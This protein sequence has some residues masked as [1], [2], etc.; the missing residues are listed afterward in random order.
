MVSFLLQWHAIPLLIRS[1]H[2]RA[3]FMYMVP[4]F[5]AYY[6]SL[7]VDPGW[8]IFLLRE[9]YTQCR[10][11]RQTLQDEDTK[12]WRHTLSE[13]DTNGFTDPALWATGQSKRS[14]NPRIR[15]NANFLFALE[16]QVT[17][18]RQRACCASAKPSGIR[19]TLA[20]SYPR[21]A[22]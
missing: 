1:T 7:A 9:A 20:S 8:A 12:L 14:R 22:T 5:L 21:R 15:M 10:L 4:P 18:G 13:R 11:Y 3:D 6:G 16:L 2:R 19:D 17:R